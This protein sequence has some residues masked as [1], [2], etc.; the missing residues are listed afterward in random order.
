MAWTKPKEKLSPLDEWVNFKNNIMKSDDARSK[1]L[2]RTTDT[3]M[4]YTTKEKAEAYRKW[5]NYYA[6]CE[7]SE[8]SAIFH[9]MKDALKSKNFRV[10]K[11]G[12]A[13]LFQLKQEKGLIPQ[14]QCV[15][16][17]LIR[18]N[19]TCST[20]FRMTFAAKASQD[21]KEAKTTGI[22]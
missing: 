3:W 16:P 17:Y 13:K 14:P 15:D 2:L 18:H 1:E 5:D 9:D 21:Q 20:Y 7:A 10:I 19:Q 8:Q 4:G 12:I 22:F 6:E 11:D